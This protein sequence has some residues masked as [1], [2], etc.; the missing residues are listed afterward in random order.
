MN[1]YGIASVVVIVSA[2]L[3]LLSGL[4]SPRKSGGED[5]DGAAT[6]PR[7]ADFFMTS[8]INSEYN[9]KGERFFF[10]K[11][12]RGD[13]YLGDASVE[14]TKPE[15]IYD[16]PSGEVWTA[17]ANQGLLYQ[18]TRKIEM[19]GDVVLNQVTP[20]KPKTSI[21]APKIH[22]DTRQKLA[23]TK[24]RTLIQQ[25]GDITSSNQ[26][27]YWYGKGL[28][29]QAGRVKGTFMPNKEQ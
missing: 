27:K 23:Y 14:L 6:P 16:Q 12:D 11:A 5:S 19:Q 28:M 10:I 9:E 15:L 24:D 2:L 21:K 8:L 1:R 3:V 4:Q 18:D 29:E 22:V 26:V 7:E 17:T 20:G 25:N 13:Y